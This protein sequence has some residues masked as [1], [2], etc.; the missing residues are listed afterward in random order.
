M[1]VFAHKADKGKF[2]LGN[3]ADLEGIGDG[4]PFGAI[5]EINTQLAQLDMTLKDISYTGVSGWTPQSIVAKHRGNIATLRAQSSIAIIQADT[6]VWHHIM[7][8]NECKP[9]T[10]IYI[11]P[12]DGS[13]AEPSTVFTAR[14]DTDGKVWM[15][16]T[17]PG[18]YIMILEGT[19]LVGA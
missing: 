15:R 13:T 18:T 17:T 7:T 10:N 14:I 6:N 19:W 16:C 12:F 1:S 8:L 2:N 9:V 5:K 4:T 11:E 3:E